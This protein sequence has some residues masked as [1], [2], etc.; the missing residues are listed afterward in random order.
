VPNRPLLVSATRTVP[1]TRRNRITRIAAAA[2]LAVTAPF[3]VP[4]PASAAALCGPAGTPAPATASWPV[5]R[6][7]PQAAWPLTR[8]AG[9]TVAVIDSGV[10]ADHPVL[11]G[12]VLPGADLNLPK[13]RGWC[14]EVGHGT[15]IASII[16][17]SAVTGNEF[18]GIA[19]SAR[20]LPIRVL[21]DAKKAFDPELPLRIAQAIKLAVDNGADVINLSLETIET[22]QLADA[23][24]YA[25]ARKV[26]IV[27]AAGNQEA[28]QQRTQPAYPAG[29]P[30]VIA[31]AGVDE[32]GGHVGTSISGDYIDVAAPGLMIEGPAPGGGFRVETEGGTS[33]AA[34][35]VSGVAALVRSYYPNLT[36]DQVMQ[37]IVATADNPPEGRTGEMGFGVVNPARAVG[38]VLGSRENAALGELPPPAKATDDLAGV[39]LAAIVVTIITVLLSLLILIGRPILRRGRKRGWR[40]G[41]AGNGG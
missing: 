36:S 18:T 9:V 4:A 34:A 30:L 17:G 22:Q 27:A 33:F 2:L 21:R 40:A 16:A 3:A 14:D 6:L 5:Q 24:R 10:A 8:G 32:Q 11:K 7:D 31:V 23:V 15:L 20:I 19:P 12:K 38:A 13:H 29:Y 41:P 37:R 39:R 35:Y 28:D 25:A 26:V 1:A